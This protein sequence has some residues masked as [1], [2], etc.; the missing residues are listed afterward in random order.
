M[1]CRGFTGPYYFLLFDFQTLFAIGWTCLAV[2]MLLFLYYCVNPLIQ[3]LEE[4]HNHT[5]VVDKELKARI[6]LDQ[7]TSDL[8]V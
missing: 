5:A 3:A 8:G 4:S 6:Q 7:N 1:L 2:A